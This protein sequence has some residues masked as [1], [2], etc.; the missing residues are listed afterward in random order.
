[1][2][3][4]PGAIALFVLTLALGSAFPPA[5]RGQV[6]AEAVMR[7]R[8]LLSDAPLEAGWVVLHRVSA[9]EQGEVD[10][11]RVGREG[12]FTLRLPAVPRAD[13]SDVYF[14]SI[15][16]QGILYFGRPV[17]LPVHLDSLYT[18][19]TWDTAAAPS[20][21][22]PVSLMSRSLF[23]EEVSDGSWQ[24]TDLYQLRNGGDRT[25]VPGPE[26]WVW[27]HP[28]P[29]GVAGGEVTQVDMA[30]SAG[31]V[32]DGSVLVTAPFPP[33]ERLFVVRYALPEPFTSVPVAEGTEGF[34]ILVR[35]PA[36]PVEVAGLEQAPPVELDGG[37]IFRRFVSGEAV[38]STVAIAPGDARRDPPV[39]W[40]A[41]L[42]TLALAAVAG[43]TLRGGLGRPRATPPPATFGDR[44]A[45]VL[46]VARLDEAFHALGDATPE[47][48]GAYEARREELLR[49]LTQLG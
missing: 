32:Q 14:A 35:E 45:L 9:E 8:V 7:G 27:S 26:G 30:S 19:Q 39:R 13:G 37:G 49:R 16:H 4:R 44:A 22:G 3:P 46:E 25:L 5:A 36:P 47:E 23:L 17:S 38:P 48:R 34:E 41:V 31:S 42:L 33:G 12:S 2:S 1:M 28:L 18:L 29:A 6:P 21:G 24:V 10:S 40:F 15:R 11:V 20:S 43:W